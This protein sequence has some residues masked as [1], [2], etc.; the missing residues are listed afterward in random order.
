MC[1]GLGS[2]GPRCP[3]E[4]P[5]SGDASLSHEEDGD[6]SADEAHTLLVGTVPAGAPNPFPLAFKP[7]FGGSGGC[8]VGAAEACPKRIP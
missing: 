2:D 5:Q 4:L 7:Q 6:T 3:D 1:A 8:A